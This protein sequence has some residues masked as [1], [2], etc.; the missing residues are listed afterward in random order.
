MSLEC[1]NNLAFLEFIFMATFYLWKMNLVLY[2][3]YSSII[4]FLD[5]Y[6]NLNKETL[7]FFLIRNHE[8]VGK[9]GKPWIWGDLM[10]LGVTLVIVSWSDPHIG[11]PTF[12]L[13][14]F[15]GCHNKIS[16]YKT[17]HS[18]TARNSGG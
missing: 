3:T 9:Y 1:G 8:A 12:I 10:D 18:H 16:D 6:L 7:F 4:A 17:T 13:A 14:H 15:C 2:L 11:L 5:V